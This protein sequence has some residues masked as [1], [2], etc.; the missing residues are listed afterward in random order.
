MS[1]QPDITL[2][3]ALTAACA[4]ATRHGVDPSITPADFGIQH[5]MTGV[6]KATYIDS[7]HAVTVTLDRY[8][9]ADHD[10]ARL[11]WVH[12][13]SDP[14]RPA[15]G[16]CGE[17]VACRAVPCECRAG[18]DADGNIRMDDGRGALVALADHSRTHVQTWRD[19]SQ[20]GTR[21]LA[22]YDAALALFDREAAGKS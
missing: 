2:R 8:G 17:C 9:E 12:R 16:P 14:D 21:F 15:C 13:E 11:D 19:H 5:S 1:D 4:F 10:V 3:T 18:R 22:Q 7:S 6:S 20:P